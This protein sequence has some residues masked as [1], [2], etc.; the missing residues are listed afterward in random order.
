MNYTNFFKIY[1]H[2]SFFSREERYANV[3]ENVW[4]KNVNKML[5]DI[6]GNILYI[7]I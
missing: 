1:I 2:R 6:Y 4:S 3:I 7:F 5:K